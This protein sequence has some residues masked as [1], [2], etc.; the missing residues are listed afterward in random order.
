MTDDTKAFA[1]EA[2]ETRDRIA[3][4]IDELQARLSPKALV[5]NALG[6]LG[7]AGSSAVASMKGAASGHPLMLAAAGL[8]V[9]IALL[10]RSRGSRTTVDYGDS[11]AAYSDYDDGYAANLVGTPTSGDKARAHLDAWQH[12]AHETVGD[13]PLAVLAVGAAT[14]A[15]LGAVIPVSAFEMSLFSEAHAR[16]AAASD[17]AMAAIRDELHPSKMSLKGGVGGLTDRLSQS[18]A[19]V[20]HEVTATLGRPVTTR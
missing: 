7:E 4:T 10:A 19:T 11:Y 12:Q 15:V 6:S 5:D 8:A 18:A 3:D 17:A 13:N 16:I 2:A 1:S 9:G 20:L 14:G